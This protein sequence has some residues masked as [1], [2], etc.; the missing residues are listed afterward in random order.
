LKTRTISIG[1]L[2]LL[3][4]WLSLYN[5]P[6]LSRFRLAGV[7]LFTL[8]LRASSVISRKAK[9]FIGP[10]LYSKW[11]RENLRL[12]EQ[13]GRFSFEITRLKELEDENERLRALLDFQQ[14]LSVASIS[15]EVIGSDSA[16]LS[17]SIIID[18]GRR[19]NLKFGMAVISE[20]GVVG[21]IVDLNSNISRV[22][23]LE[24]PDF[25]LGVVIQRTREHGLFVGGPRGK[26]RVVYLDPDS[27]VK[28]GDAVTSFPSNRL[29]PKGLLLGY[30]EEVEDIDAA[31]HKSAVVRMAVD[32]SRLEEVLCIE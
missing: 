30:V 25:R 13:L 7:N 22:M 15:A 14:G 10:R 9:N 19:D 21:R 12:K 6:C 5:P 23:I 28:K 27:D 16:L 1:V 20:E 24:D 3:F 8:P 31:L 17:R 18:R 11:V 32:Y 29:F 2:V 4:I 26:A